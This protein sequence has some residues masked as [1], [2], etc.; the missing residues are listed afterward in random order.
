MKIIHETVLEDAAK[1]YAENH[2]HYSPA[3]AGF[4]AGARWAEKRLERFFPPR[5]NLD[6]VLNYPLLSEEMYLSEKPEE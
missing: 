2:E 5:G 4:I 1:I 3:C 6:E